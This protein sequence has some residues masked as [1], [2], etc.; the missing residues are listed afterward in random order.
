MRDARGKNP[1]GFQ[2]VQNQSLFLDSLA[3]CDI[4]Q[5]RSALQAGRGQHGFDPHH[6]R[7]LSASEESH[8]T[9]IPAFVREDAGEEVRENRPVGLGNIKQKALF[10]QLRSVRTDQS[11]TGQ[12][13]FGNCPFTVECQVA[14]RGKIVKGAVFLRLRFRFAPGT[15]EFV[16]LHLQLNLMDLQLVDQSLG[17]RFGRSACS[18]VGFAHAPFGVIPQVDEIDFAVRF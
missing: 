17:V 1:G 16:V 7:G 8:L 9:R 18:R 3:F 15:P 6:N 5:H 14:D 2:P 4:F 13:G 11:G 10:D 12:I